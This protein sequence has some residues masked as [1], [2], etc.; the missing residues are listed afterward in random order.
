MW[1]PHFYSAAGMKRRE[2]SYWVLPRV[3]LGEGRRLGVP[4]GVA[5]TKTVNFQQAWEL[6]TPEQDEAQRTLVCRFLCC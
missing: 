6:E 3:R 2:V 4:K 1:F 5:I